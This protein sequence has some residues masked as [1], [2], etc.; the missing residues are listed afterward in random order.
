M[1]IILYSTVVFAGDTTFKSDLNSGWN[2][3]SYALPLSACERAAV[4]LIRLLGTLVLSGLL[5]MVGVI[6]LNNTAGVGFH[7]GYVILQL[8]I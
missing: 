4:K 3:Y 5:G 2:N 1:L 6:I 8:M 7:I